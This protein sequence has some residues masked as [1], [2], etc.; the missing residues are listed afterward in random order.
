MS[1]I[2]VVDTTV[3][4]NLLNVP[5]HNQ[6]RDRIHRQFREFVGAQASFI[7]PLAVVIQTGNHIADLPNGNHRWRWSGALRDQ[8]R[9][10]LQGE[11]PW[12]PMPIPDSDRVEKWLDRFPEFTS[13]GR[14]Y[15]VSALSIVDAWEDTR[16]I[17]PNRRVRVWS[18]NQ[19]LEIYDSVG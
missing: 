12:A 4:L 5:H 18:L 3:L 2:L 9:K 16:R 10:V 17:H 15:G 13:H 11:E 7:L 14:G 1:E 8:V 19:R 6:N